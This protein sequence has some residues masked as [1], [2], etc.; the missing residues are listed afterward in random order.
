LIAASAKADQ[1]KI[2]CPTLLAVG[3]QDAVTPLAFQQAIRQSVPH[4]RLRVLPATAH[5]TMME[6]PGEFNAL[7][8][9]WLA[10]ERG[11]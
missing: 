2:S 7:V 8:L 5:Y 4:A 1:P 3:D 9:E 10:E 11:I 6:R